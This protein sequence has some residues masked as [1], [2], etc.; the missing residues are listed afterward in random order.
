MASVNKVILLGN[1][2]A[3]PEL[4]YTSGQP[5]PGGDYSVEFVQTAGPITVSATSRFHIIVL[6]VN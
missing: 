4:R 2:G 6:I 5:L 1:L 3:D